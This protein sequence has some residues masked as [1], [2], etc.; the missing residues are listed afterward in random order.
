MKNRLKRKSLHNESGFIVADFLFAFV[1]TIGVGIFIF[2]ITFSLATIEVGQYIVWSTARNYAAGNISQIAARQ[3]AQEKFKALAEQFPL[4][5]NVGADSSWFELSEA[6][7]KISDDLTSDDTALGITGADAT[8]D[9]RQPWTGASTVI[10]LKL[11]SGL[12]I[13]FLGKVIADGNT[14]EFPIRAFL[15]RNVSQEECKA[16]YSGPGSGNRIEKGIKKLENSKLA[17]GTWGLD[18]GAGAG[19]LL[20]GEDN[21]C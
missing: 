17:A 15:I 8:N 9:F 3:Q 7:L 21:G 6:D 14:L 16:F 13:P 11:F 2:A 10:R 1:M 20:H 4:L 12:T 5:T 19:D 18:G